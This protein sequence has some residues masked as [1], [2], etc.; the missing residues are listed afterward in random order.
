L[1]RDGPAALWSNRNKLTFTASQ[2]RNEAAPTGVPGAAAALGWWIAALQG[3]Y[4]FADR[5]AN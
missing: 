1:E 5:G 3:W 2:L 4:P